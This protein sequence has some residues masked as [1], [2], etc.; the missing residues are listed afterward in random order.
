[1]D[2]LFDKKIKKYPQIIHL[3]VPLISN[4]LK[5]EP[6]AV[7]RGRV[8]RTGRRPGEPDAVP[9]GRVRRQGV[10]KNEVICMPR[11]KREQSPTGVY[12]WIVRGM[13]KKNLF[14]EA[15]DYARFQHL[16]SE[17]KNACQITIHHYCLMTNHVHMLLRAEE[18]SGPGCP[19]RF[20]YRF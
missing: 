2:H 11:K 3:F 8:R 5:R 15:E 19:D 17:Q 4:H 14:H 13:N 18:Y 10:R 12:H 6:D 20:L 9:R 7:P 1:M 16:L